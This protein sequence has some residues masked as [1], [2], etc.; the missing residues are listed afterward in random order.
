MTTDTV[1]VAVCVKQGSSTLL[2]MDGHLAGSASSR[3]FATSATAAIDL[4]HR[5]NNSGLFAGTLD[6]FA[7][8]D[9][10]LSAEDAL[11]LYRAGTLAGSGAR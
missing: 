7:F 8:F 6:E 1:T 4:A 9:T 5:G 2:Y 11:A 10:V 3:T